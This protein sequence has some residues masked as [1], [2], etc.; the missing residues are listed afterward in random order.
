VLTEAWQPVEVSP[1]SIRSRILKAGH[2]KSKRHRRGGFTHVDPFEDTESARRQANRVHVLA[3]FTHVDPFEDTERRVLYAA[4]T[5]E[6]RFTHVDPF[7]DTERRTG[8]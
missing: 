2:A 1:T 8:L 4:P 5:A 3:G 7:E 6:Q